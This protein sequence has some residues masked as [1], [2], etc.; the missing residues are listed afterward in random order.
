MK[1]KLLIMTILLF[2]LLQSC[3]IWTPPGSDN[4]LP[5]CV[6]DEEMRIELFDL[7][8][9]VPSG[10]SNSLLNEVPYDGVFRSIEPIMQINGDYALN[11]PSQAKLSVNAK[12]ESLI[13]M[14]EETFPYKKDDP[15]IKQSAI[16]IPIP[17]KDLGRGNS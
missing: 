10:V 14:G 5:E 17:F 16:V 3:D 12:V 9:K 6:W 11:L 8:L 13:C 1:N 7:Q 15:E 2:G 4:S